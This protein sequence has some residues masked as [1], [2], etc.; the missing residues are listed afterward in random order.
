MVLARGWSGRRREAGLLAA[1]SVVS[2]LLL[3]ARWHFGLPAPVILDLGDAGTSASHFYGIERSGDI[4]FRWSRTISAVSLPA[5]ASSQVVT[6][7]LNPARPAGSGT[8]RFQLLE[9]SKVLGEYQARAGWNS[10]TATIEPELAPD[11]RLTIASD[12]FFPS[13][14]DTRRLGLAVSQIAAAPRAGD[15]GYRWPPLLW[16]ALA[17][18]TPL[19]TFLLLLRRSPGYR[20]AGMAASLFLPYLLSILLPAQIALPGAAWTFGLAVVLALIFSAYELGAQLAWQ[21]FSAWLV[22]RIW[23]ELSAVCI[24]LLGVAVAFTWPVASRLGSALPGWPGDNFAFLYK[25]WWFRTAVLNLHLWPFFDPNSYA[26]FG[27]NLAQGE[28]TLINTMP[29]I[30]LG[31]LFGDVASYNILAL[32]SFVIS[33]LGAYLLVKE[34]TGSRSA[35]LVACVVF[36]FSPYRMAQYAGHLQLLG[37]GWIAFAFYFVERFVHTGKTRYGAFAGLSLA[38]TALSAWYYAYMVGLA[39]GLYTLAR[40]ATCRKELTLRAIAR[41]V[42]AAAVVLLVLV[43]PIALPSIQLWQ[44]GDLTHS[45]KAADEHSAAP[46]DYLLPNELQPLWGELSMRAHANENVIESSLYLGVVPL[47]LFLAGSALWWRRKPR[48]GVGLWGCWVALL[49]VSVLLSLGLTLHDLQGQVLVPKGSGVDAIRLPGAILYDWLPLYSSMRAYARFGVLASLAIALLAGSGLSCLL[50][51]PR[52]R[53]YTAFVTLVVLALVMADFWSAPYSWG[54][55]NVQPTKLSAYLAAAPPG[56][57]M[58]IPLESTQSGPALFAESYYGKPITYGYDTFEPP[59]WS[60]SKPLL[61]K[62][63]SNA[64]LDLLRSWGVRYIVVSANA[65]GANWQG[66]LDYLKS[67]SRLKHLADFNEQRTWQVDP[68]VLDARP[69]LDTYAVPEAFAL[70]EL[71]R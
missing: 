59:Q 69:D 40:F 42:A 36:A 13:A 26:P 24:F 54:T 46:L 38:L 9:G 37:T 44:Q 71:V 43:G 17:A 55:S 67:F 3:I 34:V 51:G 15:I 32:L 63:P 19:L 20:I 16:L 21:R 23:R 61:A 12:T 64:T 8:V 57:V 2:L 49:L 5:L 7:T 62:F 68:A 47:A 58:Q 56:A 18:L 50:A 39:L 25:L 29:G 35:A 70:F 45:A 48:H 60:A 10:Y 6:V 1:F 41:G 22:G 30:I 27:F 4:A 52:A 65:Y 14:N 31:T 11:L 66:T 33:G 53:R 28:P